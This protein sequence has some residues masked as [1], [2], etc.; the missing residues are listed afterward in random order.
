MKHHS[1]RY[2]N[3]MRLYH[4]LESIELYYLYIYII[5]TFWKEVRN[6]NFLYSIEARRTKKGGIISTTAFGF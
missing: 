1:F 2:F 5:V 3:L 4:N 6:N